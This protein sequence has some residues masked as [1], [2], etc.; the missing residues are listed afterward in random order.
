MRSPGVHI[1]PAAEA[2]LAE[3][4]LIGGA[5]EYCD[6]PFAV[7]DEKDLGPSA[8]SGL[9]VVLGALAPDAPLRRRLRQRRVPTVFAGRDVTR[10]HLGQREAPDEHELLLHGEPYAFIA[11][12]AGDPLLFE[13]LRGTAVVGPLLDP[14][15][16]RTPS[17][18]L[19]QGL[20]TPLVTSVGCGR[21]CPYCADGPMYADLYRERFGRRSR[22]WRDLARDI[23]ALKR[24]GGERLLLLADRFL[25]EDAGENGE[26]RELAA[27]WSREL[28]RP[29]LS[30]TV[31]TVEVVNNR[32]TL[33]LLSQH[34]Q[35]YPRLWVDRLEDATSL[36]QAVRFFADRRLSVRLSCALAG[37]GAT[38][39]GVR[40]ELRTLASLADVMSYLPPE[41]QILVAHDLFSS[42]PRILASAPRSA[43]SAAREGAPRELPGGLLTV[44][45][46]A[47]DVMAEELRRVWSGERGAPLRTIVEAALEELERAG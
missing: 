36:L 18:P 13:Q 27:N 26:L 20:W 5:L 25:A 9:C 15:Q 42:R 38:I 16:Y 37:P 22:P 45:G 8:E 44:M 41:H 35:L 11:R 28:G 30:F 2:D 40:E 43:P 29:A 19:R 46:K 14:R 47:R 7:L 6:I 31:S 32:D 1:V 34:G 10:R 12:L 33:E 3:V 17:T 24:Q 4:T 21:S 23:V 39:E